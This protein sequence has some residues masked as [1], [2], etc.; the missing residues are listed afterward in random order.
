MWQN[1][2]RN[3]QGE[4]SLAETL[5]NLV[6]ASKHRREPSARQE[7]SD[8]VQRIIDALEE[9][10]VAITRLLQTCGSSRDFGPEQQ[11]QFEKLLWHRRQLIAKLEKL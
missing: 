4:V 8:Q 3:K 5:R 9:D 2:S 10:S 11:R 7:K 1:S 6:P